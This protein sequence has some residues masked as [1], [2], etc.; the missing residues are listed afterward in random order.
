MVIFFYYYNDK[1]AYIRDVILCKIGQ[2]GEHA[3]KRKEGKEKRRK[4]RRR[5]QKGKEGE[6]ERE[7][8]RG[9]R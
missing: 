9:E 3:S 4:G 6:G 2:G 5:R 7:D 1:G 8:R